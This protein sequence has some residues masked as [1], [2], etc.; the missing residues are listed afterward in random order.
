MMHFVLPQAWYQCGSALSSAPERSVWQTLTSRSHRDAQDTLPDTLGLELPLCAGAFKVGARTSCRHGRFAGVGKGTRC[1][2]V[3][4]LRVPPYCTLVAAHGISHRYLATVSRRT[5]ASQARMTG[6]WQ[7]HA[8]RIR[9]Q[10]TR[11]AAHAM[12]WQPSYRQTSFQSA[13][14]SPTRRSAPQRDASQPTSTQVPGPPC[15]WGPSRAAAP[16]A[17]APAPFVALG[18]AHHHFAV[19]A[20]PGACSLQGTVARYR[21]ELPHWQVWPGRPAGMVLSAKSRCICGAD[22][23]RAHADGGQ[24]HGPRNHPTHPLTLNCAIYVT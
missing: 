21:G 9:P 24:D 20:S 12:R 8:Q 15:L 1:R 7:L 6:V 18:P 3:W 2:C 22:L 17:A 19:I 10:P 4:R 14:L 11:K 16:R 13:V 23:I 5:R